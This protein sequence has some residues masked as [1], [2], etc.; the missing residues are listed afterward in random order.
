MHYCT[1][2]QVHPW[3]ITRITRIVTYSPYRV[4]HVTSPRA[5]HQ[6]QHHLFSLKNH[7]LLCIFRDRAKNSTTQSGL[8]LPKLVMYPSTTLQVDSE[9]PH[10]S[11]RWWLS[12]PHKT[13]ASISST[14]LADRHYPRQSS[15]GK[16]PCGNRR[17]TI[18][19]LEEL[20]GQ[21]MI[22]AGSP[23]LS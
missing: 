2:Y 12:L 15:M 11:L 16:G 7:H 6:H 8:T 13:T 9:F 14:N 10:W 20:C 17:H 21:Q 4:S 23:E 18:S 1:K 3:V 22:L 5:S 19:R